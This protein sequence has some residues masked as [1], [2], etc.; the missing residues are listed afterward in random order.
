[1]VWFFRS[2][3]ARLFLNDQGWSAAKTVTLA[4]DSVV[5]VSIKTNR[6]AGGGGGGNGN[7]MILGRE[8]QVPA[9]TPPNTVIVRKV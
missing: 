8:E 7:V 4:E 5:D 6:P 3:N 1:M 2:T 9:G